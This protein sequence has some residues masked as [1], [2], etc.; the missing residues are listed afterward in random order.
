VGG[1]TYAKTSFGSVSVQRVNGHLT[2]E[3]SNDSVTASSITGDATAKTSFGSVTLNDIAGSISVDNQNGTVSVSTARVSAP[4]RNITIKTSFAPIQVRI[5]EGTGFNLIAR[6]SFG[7]INSELPVTTS[8]QIGGDSLNGKIG[9]GG[10]TL[11]LTN[12]NG[13][14][15]LLK[16]PK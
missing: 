6:T 9:N 5:P 13:A 16:L 15:E 1:D 4:C 2:I 8:G 11:S 7:H 3:N 14:I 10:C 12:S